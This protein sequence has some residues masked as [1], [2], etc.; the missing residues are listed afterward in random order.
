MTRFVSR[1]T[2]MALL[3]VPALLLSAC[4]GDKPKTQAMGELT[5]HLRMVGND[6]KQYGTVE[7]NPVG[8]GQVYD[9]NG[10]LIG[11]ITAP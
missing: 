8:G 11:N 1:T 9:A 2:T 5:H 6:G 7:L 3:V 10:R 4:E